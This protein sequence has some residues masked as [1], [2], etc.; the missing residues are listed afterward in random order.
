MLCKPHWNC[1]KF[2]VKKI[3]QHMDVLSAASAALLT[4]NEATLITSTKYAWWIPYNFGPVKF[5]NQ[6]TATRDCHCL[7]KWTCADVKQ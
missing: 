5:E 4:D 2:H 3:S 1:K 6:K 7:Y